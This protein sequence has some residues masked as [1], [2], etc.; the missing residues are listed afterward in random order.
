MPFPELEKYKRQ[1]PRLAET[2]SATEVYLR[3]LLDRPI[4]STESL[5]HAAFDIVPVLL[6]KSL[7]VEEGY[8][9]ALLKVFEDA[10]IIL[11]SYDVYC[12][13]TDNFIASFHSKNDLPESL[14]CPF[15][16]GT[17]HSIDEYFVELIFH[18]APTIKRS[19]QSLMAR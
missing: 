5:D 15:E 16:V 14:E 7:G 11:H 1:S 18:F 6:A 19:E 13:N 9:I 17:E 2:L 10:G 4:R 12:P 3:E 8:A